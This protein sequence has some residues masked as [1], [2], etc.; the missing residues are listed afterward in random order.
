MSVKGR[1]S[2]ESVFS[3]SIQALVEEGNVLSEEGEDIGIL[4]MKSNVFHRCNGGV[5]GFKRF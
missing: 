4:L 3:G 1:I 2:I 5:Q